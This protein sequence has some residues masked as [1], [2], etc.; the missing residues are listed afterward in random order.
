VYGTELEMKIVH[1]D[2][3]DT[4]IVL[5]ETHVQ[6]STLLM[7]VGETHVQADTCSGRESYYKVNEHVMNCTEQ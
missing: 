3:D 2:T 6:S 7:F 5:S 1:A 4:T